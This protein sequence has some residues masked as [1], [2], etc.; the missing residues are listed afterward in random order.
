MYVVHWCVEFRASK[1]MQE[2]LLGNDK[3]EV[4]WDTECLNVVGESKEEC[5]GRYGV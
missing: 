4:L 1:I 3:I 5:E 2:I